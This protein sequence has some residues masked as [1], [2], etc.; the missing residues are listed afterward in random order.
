MEERGFRGQ[1]ETTPPCALAES[2][3]QELSVGSLLPDR[4]A[5]GQQPK[6]RLSFPTCGSFRLDNNEI[7][8]ERHIG[9]NAPF[10]LLFCQ[11]HRAPA[12]SSR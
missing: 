11:L 10:L 5:H 3:E 2:H 6:V 12:I 4:L 1:E 7:V 9:S 8:I